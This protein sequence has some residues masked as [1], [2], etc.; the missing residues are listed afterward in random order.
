MGNHAATD[1]QIDF[2]LALATQTHAEGTYRFLSELHK[3]PAGIHLSQR[4]THGNLS[5]ARASEII[6]D[7]KDFQ[8]VAARHEKLQ[9]DAAKRVELGLHPFAKLPGAESA[10]QP[11]KP[12]T[13]NNTATATAKQIALIKRLARINPAPGGVMTSI[14]FVA[15][16]TDLTRI[17]RRDASDLIDTLTDHEM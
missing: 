12:R 5:K 17:T 8:A 16:P 13:P 15:I 10:R 9:A 3:H 11:A 2:I 6:D 1:K 4:E 14:G 7:L